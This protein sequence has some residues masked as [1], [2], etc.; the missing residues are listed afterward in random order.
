MST[1]ELKHYIHE[2]IDNIDNKETLQIINEMIQHLFT[3]EK[4]PNLSD[5]QKSRI[6]DSKYQ[7][8]NGKWASNE[9]VIKHATNWKS[10]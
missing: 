10:W 6:V 7:I 3:E 2:S 9:Q 1:E 8:A 4:N 5:D